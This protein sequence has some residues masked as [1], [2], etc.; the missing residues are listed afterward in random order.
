[1]AFQIGLR[2]EQTISKGELISTQAKNNTVKEI[3]PLFPV[4]V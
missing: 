1:M 3:I 4:L 2:A